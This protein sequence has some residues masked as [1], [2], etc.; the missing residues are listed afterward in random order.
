MLSLNQNAANTEKEMQ[1][2]ADDIYRVAAP[3]ELP[4]E[5]PRRQSDPDA[6]ESGWFE[7]RYGT[8]LESCDAVRETNVDEA[9]K[10]ADMLVRRYKAV[11]SC[12]QYAVAGICMVCEKAAPDSAVGIIQS[13]K[14]NADF[15]NNQ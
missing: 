12:K 5:Q 13:M 4:H 3:G 2:V 14:A 6:R 1:N 8:L 7:G 15:I 10:V 9:R 11:H